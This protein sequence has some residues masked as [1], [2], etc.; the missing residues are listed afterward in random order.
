M[1]RTILTWPEFQGLCDLISFNREKSRTRFGAQ[2]LNRNGFFE[3]MSMSFPHNRKFIPKSILSKS[4]IRVL[5]G[6]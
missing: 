6:V 4:E 3:M 2:K 5:L 1:K